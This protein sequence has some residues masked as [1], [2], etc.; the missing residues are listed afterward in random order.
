[1]CCCPGLHRVPPA[2]FKEQVQQT[3]LRPHWYSSRWPLWAATRL[4]HSEPVFKDENINWMYSFSESINLSRVQSSLQRQ[5]MEISWGRRGDMRR[6]IWDEEDY[7]R[8]LLKE[9]SDSCGSVKWPRCGKYILEMWPGSTLLNPAQR[10]IT[11][12]IQWHV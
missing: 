6:G 7:P 10:D 8:W 4:Q 11:V 9:A 3:K 12:L 5:W 1:M 2:G